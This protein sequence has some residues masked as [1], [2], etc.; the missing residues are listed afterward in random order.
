[1]FDNGLLPLIPLG[2]LR[3]M[4]YM[5]LITVLSLKMYEF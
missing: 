5:D 2:M 3:N 1:M 4:H